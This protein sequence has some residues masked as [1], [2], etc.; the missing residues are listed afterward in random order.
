M[1]MLCRKRNI[2][3]GRFGA[4]YRNA[5]NATATKGSGWFRKGQTTYIVAR[6]VRAKARMI[7]FLFRWFHAYWDDSGGYTVLTIPWKK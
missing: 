5:A 3:H 4:V 2:F 7:H 6:R 1:A